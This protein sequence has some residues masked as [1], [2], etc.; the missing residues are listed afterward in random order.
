MLLNWRQYAEISLHTF[1]VVIV[2]IGLNHLNQ[3]LLGC[4][5]FTIII[6]ALQNAPETFHGTI[7]DAMSHTGHTLS[8]ACSFKLTMKCPIRILKTPVAMK[9][10]LG[11]WI[12]ADCLIKCLKY[13][14]IVVAFAY[15]IG[16]NSPIINIEDS[17][18]IYLVDDNPLIPLEFRHI[19]QPLL[20]WAFSIEFSIQQIFCN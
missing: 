9:Q 6:L 15:D 11:T 13:Q 12:F 18:K 3:V 14:R 1:C 8:H 2:Y 4:K 20:V 5:S 7:V 10:R 17:G 19:R 16:N